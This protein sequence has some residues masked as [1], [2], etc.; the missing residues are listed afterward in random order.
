MDVHIEH[1]E[2]VGSVRRLRDGRLVESRDGRLSRSSYP[3]SAVLSEVLVRSPDSVVPLSDSGLAVLCSLGDGG[4]V[5][6]V[7]GSTGLSQPTVS[8]KIRQFRGLSMVRG[9]GGGYLINGSVW[10]EVAELARQ[11]SLFLRFSDPELPP[12]SESYGLCR[13]RKVFSSPSDLPL[14]RTAFSVYDRYGIDFY[15]GLNYYCTGDGDVGPQEVFEHSLAVCPAGGWR[16]RMMTLVFYLKFRGE[17]EDGGGRAMSEIGRVLSGERVDGWVPLG[18]ILERAVM[19]GVDHGKKIRGDLLPDG[20][21]RRRARPQ[22]GPVPH[23]GRGAHAFG[24]QGRH[25]GP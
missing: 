18:E 24:P 11:Y 8:R 15:P 5:S 7:I 19:Y 6:D 23:R 3:H 22:D 4:T 2:T 21:A 1:P 12:G 14:S 17:L 10:P 13:G 16:V 25:Q 20:R 9:E